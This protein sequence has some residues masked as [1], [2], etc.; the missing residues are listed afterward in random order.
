MVPISNLIG[1]RQL[2]REHFL[3]RS[4]CPLSKH[5][6]PD[7]PGL[8]PK[9]YRY[10]K[11]HIQRQTM[12]SIECI[13]CC[14]RQPYGMKQELMSHREASFPYCSN[15]IVI[16]LVQ[17]RPFNLYCAYAWNRTMLQPL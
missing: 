2:L 6:I 11:V 5:L 17:V 4:L 7:H 3:R 9:L 14:D 8:L 15:V 1:R 12:G 10:N 16:S 13:V